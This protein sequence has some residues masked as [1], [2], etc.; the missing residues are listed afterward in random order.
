MPFPS[1]RPRRL[2][3]REN[4]RQ[5]L[6]ETRLSPDQLILPLF[7]RHGKNLCKPVSS[8]PGVFQL[9]VDQLVKEAKEVFRLGIPAVILFGLPE[10]KDEKASEA[11]ATN[12]IVQQAI[13]ALKD[14]VPELLVI[15]DVCL[16]EYMS[17]GHCGVIKKGGAIDND[18]SV[19]L[20][21]MTAFSHV[22]AGADWV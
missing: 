6:R 17:H 5:M 3:S 12:G 16:C 13:R 8:M 4:V 2:R 1:E 21:S 19:E 20:L 7:V 9:S 18:S 22:Q 15:T 14:K 11:Y 10:K